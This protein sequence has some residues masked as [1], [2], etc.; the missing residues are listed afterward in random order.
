MYVVILFYAS[1][2]TILFT[3]RFWA[4][5]IPYVILFCGANKECGE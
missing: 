4:M 3:Y 1:M 5:M 2:E